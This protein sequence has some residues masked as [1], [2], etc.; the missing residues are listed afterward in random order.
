MHSFFSG[1]GPGRSASAQAERSWGPFRKRGMPVRDVTSV[2]SGSGQTPV[3]IHDLTV[4]QDLSA[5]EHAAAL[6][7]PREQPPA[8]V[9]GYAILRNIGDGAYGSVWLAR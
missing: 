7:R 8:T 3:Q 9:A 2:R 5:Q 1:Q 6:S 4:T